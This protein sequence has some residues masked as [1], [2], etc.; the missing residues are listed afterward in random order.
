[1]TIPEVDTGLGGKHMSITTAYF[2]SMTANPIS[3]PAKPGPETREL[4]VFVGKW[5]IVG[6]NHDG[7]AQGPD[8]PVHGEETYQWL[9]GGFFICSRWTHRFGGGSHEGLSVLGFDQERHGLFAHNVDNLG[10]VRLYPLTVRG[11]TWSYNGTSERATQEFSSDSNSFAIHWEVRKG[12]I[13]APLCDL[14]GTRV[15]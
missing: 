10:F 1:M 8:T 4:E 11:R 15:Q 12:P 9:P 13:W 3:V 2:P 14:K 6:H 7:A 5:K